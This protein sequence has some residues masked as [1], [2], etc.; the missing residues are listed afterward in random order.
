MQFCVGLYHI[1]NVG[2]I[3]CKSIKNFFI[4]PSLPCFL[5]YYSIWCCFI[6]SPVTNGVAQLL[7]LLFAYPVISW[8]APGSVSRPTV[9]LP[10]YLP[11]W[12]AYP[13]QVILF[14][15]AANWEL[16]R[17]DQSGTW[18]TTKDEKGRYKAG[19]RWKV[20]M[21][22][23][24]TRYFMLCNLIEIKDIYIRCSTLLAI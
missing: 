3:G 16:Q 23:L 17:Q 18:G 19:K 2:K 1:N 9:S 24:E 22:L 6:V 4:M 12:Q 8:Q 20:H 10:V 11:V 5:L 14:S 13:F 7:L 15:D 21:V